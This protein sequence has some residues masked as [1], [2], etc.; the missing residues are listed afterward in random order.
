MTNARR[1]GLYLVLLGCADFVLIGSALE[2]AVPVTAVDFRVVYYSARC[3]LEHRD[4]YSES[5]LDY[6]Y[7][8]Q[9]GETAKDSPQIRRSER[10]YN[11]LPTAF[12]ITLPFAIFP[13]GPAHLLWLAFTACSVILASYLMWDIGAQFAPILAGALA[14]L[15]LA[16]SELFLIL[17]NP[18]GIA[19]SLCV[20]A[21]WCFVRERF[22]YLGILCLAVSL[23][24]K[25]HDSGL[26]WLYFLLAGGVLRRRAW[27]VLLIVIILSMPAI[28]WV[29]Y[30]APNWLHELQSILATYSSHGDVNDPGPS[31]MASHGIGMVI[32]L[33]ALISVF[34]DDPRFY[35]P[36]TYLVCGALLL[37]W[38]VKVL[39]SPNTSNTAWFALAPIA[40]LSVLPVYHRI[41]DARLLL[42]TIPAC[43]IL[44]KEGG[45]LAWFA[46]IVDAIGILLTGG[47]P[48]AIFFALLKHA[49]LPSA[50]S[51][52]IP[53]IV[54]QVFPA[55]LAVLCVGVM[56][57]WVFVRR[58]PGGV[59][60]SSSETEGKLN[61]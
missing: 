44:W 15:S 47:L 5:D 42:L 19:I 57:L 8:T 35:N 4:P 33:Q 38:L 51:S 53:L 43:A 17:G 39:R 16:N 3:L 58:R 6:V 20:I 11:Y 34:R 29:S 18:A 12:P 55:P 26:I 45:A 9:G 22:E 7:R 30:V 1:D 49:H 41:Y 60:T 24:L 52:G 28:L 48:W 27:Q 54:I 59:A 40:A 50:I 13:F 56:F 32:S 31:S 61:V 36:L 46:P 21:T 37:V 25:P 23:M 14:C 2:N 10:R